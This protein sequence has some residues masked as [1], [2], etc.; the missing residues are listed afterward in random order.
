MNTST[1]T[2]VK[3]SLIVLSAIFW[4]LALG[5]YIIE[6]CNISNFLNSADENVIISIFNSGTILTLIFFVLIMISCLVMI[7]LLSV[8][9]F[10]KNSKKNLSY[11]VVFSIVILVSIMLVIFKFISKA[12]YNF[13]NI[14]DIPT[15]YGEVYINYLIN[16][17]NFNYFCTTLIYIFV[18]MFLLSLTC[19]IKNEKK[20]EFENN[21]E[22]EN[23]NKNN[24]SDEIN[25][26]NNIYATKRMELEQSLYEKQEL[27][28]II[29]LQN[30]INEMDKQINSKTEIDNK[31]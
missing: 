9:I 6:L 5:Y 30:R 10:N 22:I 24:F 1:N 8:K 7:I 23:L 21:G 29:E 17:F 12:S 3:I 26:N 4:V 28:K 25:S 11:L 14:Y 13:L 20:I 2:Y 16:C 18:S 27:L 31:L 15:Y 19:F